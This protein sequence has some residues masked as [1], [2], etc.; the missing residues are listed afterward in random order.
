MRN[1]KLIILGGLAYYVVTLLISFAT[2]P[3]V[4]NNL[5]KPEYKAHAELWRPELNEE[6]PNMMALMPRWTTTGLLGAFLIAAIYAWI[7]PA[8]SGPG[9]KRG[10]QY[11]TMLAVLAI[12]VGALGYSG[13]FNASD[14]IW[15]VWAI[16][17]FFYYLPGGAVLGWLGG[18]LLR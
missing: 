16:E 15:A 9:W 10:L 14:K 12:T 17:G 2:G 6:P 4:H 13:V 5:L 1:W 8:F 18:K 3:I 11:G 7:H